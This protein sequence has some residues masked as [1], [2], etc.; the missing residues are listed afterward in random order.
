MPLLLR[1]SLC[2]SL[3]LLPK[4]PDH[5]D[6]LLWLGRDQE[7][8]I[9]VNQAK[10][11][12]A[13]SFLGYGTG[14][15]QASEHTCSMPGGQEAEPPP[16]LLRALPPIHKVG[17]LTFALLLL[18]SSDTRVTLKG[19]ASCQQLCWAALQVSTGP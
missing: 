12:S 13:W 5:W 9:G 19:S 16:C 1:K 7:Y 15:N 2:N 3:S 11:L 10:A 8:S 17:D 4:L 6:P 14:T 18:W